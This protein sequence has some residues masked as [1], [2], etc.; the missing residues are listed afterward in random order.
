LIADGAIRV[1]GATG[2]RLPS[3]EQWNVPSLWRDS[4]DG[5][6]D[7]PPFIA[8]SF[9]GEQYRIVD[10]EVVRWNPETGGHEPSGRTL[11]G[12]LALVRS[13][14]SMEVPTWLLRDW[15]AL[16]GPLPPTVHLAPSVPIVLGG[17]Y[18]LGNLH[19]VA[20]V[21]DLRWRAQL[22]TQ[23]RDLPDGAEVRLH[24]KWEP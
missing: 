1:F 19:S 2:T 12:W 23:L 11:D 16:H 9:I 13:E 6:A 21:S 24:V 4:Y 3:V 17:L 7:G 5:L 22:A 20:A 14:A 10:G 8:E 15:E 18:D